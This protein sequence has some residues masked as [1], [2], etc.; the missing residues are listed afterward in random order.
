MGV[1]SQAR[2]ER[3]RRL[4][5]EPPP[6]SGKEE[7]TQPPA[8]PAPSEDVR[9]PA[10]GVAQ[11]PREEGATMP[12]CKP[13]PRKLAASAAPPK[14]EGR[15]GLKGVEDREEGEDS[16]AEAPAAFAFTLRAVTR[17]EFPSER[18][19]IRTRASVAMTIKPRAVQVPPRGEGENF[20]DSPTCWGR[21]RAKR[22]ARLRAMAK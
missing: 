14:A 16:I 17:S 9:E 5:E 18:R 1:N 2:Q 4:A 13:E 3:R 7:T 6:Q 19:T 20:G 15:G 21:V 12:M 10:T 11:D 22:S 8:A